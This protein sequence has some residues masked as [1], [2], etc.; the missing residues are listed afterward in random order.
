MSQNELLVL[1]LVTASLTVAAGLIALVAEAFGK[2]NVAKSAITVA[3]GLLGFDL[4]IALFG[5]LTTR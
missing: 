3:H 2:T 5:L 1:F 4:L